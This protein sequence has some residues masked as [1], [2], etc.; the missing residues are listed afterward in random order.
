MGETGPE[1]VGSGMCPTDGSAVPRRAVG[2][3]GAVLPPCPLPWGWGR[4][5]GTPSIFRACAEGKKSGTV[6]LW[7]GRLYG[8]GASYL[9]FGSIFSIKGYGQFLY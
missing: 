5:E 4:L 1:E 7:L 3:V 9:L 8:N 2:S 6:R